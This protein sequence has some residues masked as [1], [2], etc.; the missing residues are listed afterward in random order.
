MDNDLFN[1]FIEFTPHKLTYYKR[2]HEIYVDEKNF[3]V[4]KSNFFPN[5]GQKFAILLHQWDMRA[6]Y[7]YN[8]CYTFAYVYEGEF[9]IIVSEHET[10]ISEGDLCIIPPGVLQKNV[11]NTD[12][13]FETP[14]IM[15]KFLIPPE[16]LHYVLKSVFFVSNPI[17]DYLSSTMSN[18][19]YSHLFVMKNHTPYAKSIVELTITEILRSLD[20]KRQNSNAAC[21][22][23]SALL[24]SYI[25]SENAEY[26]YSKTRFENK[27]TTSAIIEYIRSDVKSITLATLCEKFH[28]TPS[29]ICRLIKLRSGMTFKELLNNERLA[30]AAQ[31]LT[32]TEYDVKIIASEAGYPSIEYFYRCFKKK[33][34]VTP[35][36]YRNLQISK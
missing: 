6:L 2:S 30:F 4:K 12:K 28:Y 14:P 27:D 20:S 23:F 11:E 31:E 32:R 26:E 35:T 7:F 16:N 9:K 8:E 33:Y 3:V 25:D 10:V 13:D 15:L 24:F 17:N 34:G 36:E 18:S 22:L 21:S 19:N 1:K 29:Y 5:L